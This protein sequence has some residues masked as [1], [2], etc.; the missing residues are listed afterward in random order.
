[1]TCTPVVAALLVVAGEL[2]A[3][4][5]ELFEGD[6]ARSG[7]AAVHGAVG[8]SKGAECALRGI[9]RGVLLD[10]VGIKAVPNDLGVILRAARQRCLSFS[11]CA[12]TSV[13]AHRVVHQIVS[14]GA[15]CALRSVSSTYP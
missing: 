1:M 11:H 15:S 4:G 9:E 13:T 2:R 3:V 6:G 12:P 14:T 8:G 5:D 10:V 7:V